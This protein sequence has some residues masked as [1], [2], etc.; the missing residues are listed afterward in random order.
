MPVA[1]GYVFIE[2]LQYSAGR[3]KLPPMIR[4]A[5]LNDDKGKCVQHGGHQREK[6]DLSKNATVG[7]IP[8]RCF[9]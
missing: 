8:L 4:N 3:G 9:I 7:G 5:F 2:A 6:R 1:L